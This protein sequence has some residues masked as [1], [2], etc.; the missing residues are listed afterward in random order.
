LIKGLL[1]KDQNI[2]AIVGGQQTLKKKLHM[3]IIAH[4]VDKVMKIINSSGHNFLSI[5]LS[6]REYTEKEG[7]SKAKIYNSFEIKQ[8]ASSKLIS[9]EVEKTVEE[10]Y[11]AIKRP[12]PL[13]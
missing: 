10:I 2:I 11:E 1:T 8:G 13:T 6:Y 9:L 4:S 5:N 7:S 12:P 3:A